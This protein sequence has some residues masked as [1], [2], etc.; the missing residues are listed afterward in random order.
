VLEAGSS[1]TLNQVT[2][3]FNGTSDQGARLGQILGR[4]RW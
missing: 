3:P 2:G 4:I 1:A